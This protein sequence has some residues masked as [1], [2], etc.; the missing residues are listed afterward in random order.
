MRVKVKVLGLILVPEDLGQQ[1][2]PRSHSLEGMEF[3][4]YFQGYFHWLRLAS[5][6]YRVSVLLG[7]WF[8]MQR[9]PANCFHHCW[10]WFGLVMGHQMNKI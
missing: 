1:T 10:V 4:G 6:A 8:Q 7:Y 5:F 2:Q 3:P 9:V